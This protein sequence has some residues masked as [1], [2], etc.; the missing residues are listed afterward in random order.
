[1]K[2]FS[3]LG[4]DF[5]VIAEI[6]QNHCGDLSL[7]MDYIEWCARSGAHAVKFQNRDNKYLFSEE[8]YLAPYNSENAFA[9]T[10]GAHREFLEFS[11][12]DFARLRDKAH[13][14][15]VDFISTPFD[16]PS[17]ELLLSL[18]VDA[19]KVASFDIGNIP[20]LKLICQANLPVVISTG[21]GNLEQIT[22]SLEVLKLPEVAL[23][24][25]V[26]EYPCPPQKLN[27]RKIPEYAAL[28]PNVT[29]G[30]SDHFNGIL[31]GP[32]AYMLGARV[33]EKHVTH[34][35]S[36]KGT[37]HSFA[38]ESRG[39]QNF[40]RDLNRTREML[41]LEDKP[42]LGDEP[43]FKKLGKSIIA[44]QK[45]PQGAII[46]PSML[47]GRIFS[48]S[49]IPVRHSGKVIGKQALGDIEAGEK[50]SWEQLS[51]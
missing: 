16:E 46:S 37:D 39:L 44:N 8:A 7:A 22:A 17:L 48:S 10:Y 13:Q 41:V 42:D 20:F 33:F 11:R 36:A 15:K 29:V 24:H 9:A 45:I 32:V 23:M 4:D 27:L 47:S 3:G 14:L 49:G 51:G 50:I 21:G 26:S 38:L 40:I 2:Y 35:R 12:D 34:D 18:G 31:S 5:Y 19:L 6:G 30:S 28:Y 43:V 25:C 1:M